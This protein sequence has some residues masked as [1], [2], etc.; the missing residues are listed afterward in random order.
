MSWHEG[1]ER[2]YAIDELR[3]MGSKAKGALPFLKAEIASGV[4]NIDTGDG[5]IHLRDAIEK[6]IAKIER[7]SK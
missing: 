6:A 2:L 7:A 5:V 4:E 1:Y 3:Y